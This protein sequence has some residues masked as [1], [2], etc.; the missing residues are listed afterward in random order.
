MAGEVNCDQ[1]D[2]GNYEPGNSYGSDKRESSVML[3][4]G[5]VLRA[6]I[7][8]VTKIPAYFPPVLHIMSFRPLGN[9]R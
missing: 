1:M 9:H 8:E 6:L 3:V 4:T 7:L 2:G 5:L